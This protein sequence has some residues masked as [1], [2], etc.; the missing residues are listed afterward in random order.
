[1]REAR[2]DPNSE[3]ILT[4]PT[5]PPKPIRKEDSDIDSNRAD[6]ASGNTLAAVDSDRSDDNSKRDYMKSDQD[7]DEF[8]DDFEQSVDTLVAG[9]GAVAA[10]MDDAGR[11]SSKNNDV[12]VEEDKQTDEDSDEFED[13][14]EQSVDTLAPGEGAVAANMDTN[15]NPGRESSKNNDVV[16]EDEE[17]NA[18]SDKG[19]SQLDA[20]NVRH[21]CSVVKKR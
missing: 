6:S 18:G 5:G 3:Q 20:K 17:D 11:E 21:P 13:D 10:N 12:V 9:E 14:F 8:K 16:N 2:Q 15:S 4:N 7:L 19:G 1:M